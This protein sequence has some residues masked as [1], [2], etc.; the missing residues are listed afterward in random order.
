VSWNRPEGGF[1]VCLHLPVAVDA[2][3][4]EYC[5]GEYGVL[6]TPMRFFSL[7]AGDNYELRL[8]CSYLTPE[9]IDD[10]VRRLGRF[11]RDPRACA[12]AEAA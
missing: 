7:D 3:L 9:Q 2:A 6:W 12:V 10:G 11:L 4:L 5:A 8:S 1:F